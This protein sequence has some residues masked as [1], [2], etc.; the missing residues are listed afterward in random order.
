MSLFKGKT[1]VAT[2]WATFGCRIGLLF[3]PTSGHTARVA[4]FCL[5]PLSLSLYL[6]KLFIRSCLRNRRRQI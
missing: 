4:I 3:I 6:V 5:S 2:F 1:D